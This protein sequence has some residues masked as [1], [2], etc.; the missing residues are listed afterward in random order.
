MYGIFVYNVNRFYAIINTSDSNTV[1]CDNQNGGNITMIFP[2]KL[3]TS[4]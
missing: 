3:C 4:E 2:M 1:V